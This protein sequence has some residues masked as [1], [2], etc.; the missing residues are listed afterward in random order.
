MFLS[1]EVIGHNAK[2]IDISVIA[3]SFK[4]IAAKNFESIPQNLKINRLI[5]HTGLNI[6]H[7]LIN[8]LT[9]F[10]NYFLL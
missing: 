1:T 9:E 7:P 6:M 5:F 10:N 8:D 4:F 2:H 3:V